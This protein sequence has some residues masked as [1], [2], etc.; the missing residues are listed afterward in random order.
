MPV[1]ISV[2]GKRGKLERFFRLS[3]DIGLDG[4]GF[5]AGLPISSGREVWVSFRLPEHPQP[6]RIAALV[7]EDSGMRPLPR[8][9][10]GEVDSGP[11]THGVEFQ[12]LSEPDIQTIQ[13]YLDDSAGEEGCKT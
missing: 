7:S 12:S 13:R 8:P 6:L 10:D 11:R 4:M 5:D 3:R 9:E 2:T 1:E